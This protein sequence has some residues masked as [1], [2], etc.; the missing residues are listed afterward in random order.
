MQLQLLVAQ[1]IPV[2]IMF[3]VIYVLQVDC[4]LWSTTKKSHTTNIR[5]NLRKLNLLEDGIV[6]MV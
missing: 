2:L 1:L 3:I 4:H 6:S 5:S